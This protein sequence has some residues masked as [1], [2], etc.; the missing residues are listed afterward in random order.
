M[1]PKET[2]VTPPEPAAPADSPVPVD[3]PAAATSQS[4]VIQVDGSALARAVI[5]GAGSGTVVGPKEYRRLVTDI[6][7]EERTLVVPEFRLAK[8]GKTVRGYAVPWNQKSRVIG[9]FREQ[10]SPGAFRAWLETNP[11]VFSLVDHD[12]GKP[13]ARVSAGN[14]QVGEDEF[15]C[16]YEMEPTDTSYARDLLA[17]IAGKV[18][19][20]SSFTFMVP[21][22]GDSWSIDND[23]MD[24]RTVNVAQ[25]LEVSPVAFPAYETT[26]CGMRSAAVEASPVP[27]PYDA[28]KAKE[29]R[30][31][32]EMLEE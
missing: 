24:L 30:K 19:R 6:K 13:L 18:I 22:G 28:E 16:W 31:L 25:L 14:L 26:S 21:Q 5:H 27:I 15:G 12:T 29:R 1:L 7:R 4:I 2:L 3:P 23:G 20:Q 32:L 8:A 17:N 9:W 10:F 11:D